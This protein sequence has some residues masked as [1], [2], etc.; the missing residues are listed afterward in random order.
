MRRDHK[1]PWPKSSRFTTGSSATTI[2]SSRTLDSATATAVS[3]STVP[4]PSPVTRMTCA[5]PAH[6][7]AVD[8]M[9]QPTEKP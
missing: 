8:S 3:I 4:G 7:N 5:G 6:C 9:A 1:L 2:G